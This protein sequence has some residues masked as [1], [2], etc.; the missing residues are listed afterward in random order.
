MKNNF[1]FHNVPPPE[2]EG[3]KSL[4]T[5]GRGGFIKVCEIIFLDT[6]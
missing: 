2:K 4:P 1:T 3:K 5:E 6:I